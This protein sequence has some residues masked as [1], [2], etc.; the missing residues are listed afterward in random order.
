MKTFSVL[1]QPQSLPGLTAQ[2]P[3]AQLPM[4]SVQPAAI[5]QQQA[6]SSQPSSIPA[7]APPTPQYQWYQQ[8]PPAVGSVAASAPQAQTTPSQGT[9]IMRAHMVTVAFLSTP[10]CFSDLPSPD[11]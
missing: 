11:M 5:I 9:P 7:A 3:M 8:M 4:G 10:L 2:Q 6:S 1:L